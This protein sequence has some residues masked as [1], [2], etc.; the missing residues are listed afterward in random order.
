VRTRALAFVHG[1][2]A[3]T[4]INGATFRIAAIFVVGVVTE[5]GVQPVAAPAIQF[6]TFK[7]DECTA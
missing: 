1:H 2:D 4:V 7:I 6:A 5:I 3:T